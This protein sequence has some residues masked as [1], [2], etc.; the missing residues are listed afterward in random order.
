MSINYLLLACGAYTV[1]VVVPLEM[2][3]R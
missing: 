2:A 3:K 1:D